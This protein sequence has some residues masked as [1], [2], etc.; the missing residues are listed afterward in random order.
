MKKGL[1]FVFL[2]AAVLFAVRAAAVCDP[3]MLDACYNNFPLSSSLGF[4]AAEIC[5]VCYQCGAADGVCPEDFSDTNIPP[6]TANCT[7]CN[8]PD[9]NA[10][11]YGYVYRLRTD[12]L[13]VAVGGALVKSVPTN[14]HMVSWENTTT[15][16]AAGYYTLQV[17]AGR[18]VV[19]A[20]AIGLDTQVQEVILRSHQTKEVKFFLPNASCDE[21]CTNYFDRCNRECEGINGCHYVDYANGYSLIADL[22]HE[23][24]FGDS[25]VINQTGNETTTTV[26]CKGDHTAV[27]KTPTL[28]VGGKMNNLITI[29]I[30]ALYQGRPIRLVLAE[31][32]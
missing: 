10:T 4:G 17:P 25:V 21:N 13:L 24:R 20:S 9:C 15:T 14:P 2:F 30:P 6:N 8:D 11:I 19:S 23:R 29:E 27:E 28:T 3:A 32:T 5:D 22:C 1:G 7:S 26:C 31:W 12:S 18:L 16:D